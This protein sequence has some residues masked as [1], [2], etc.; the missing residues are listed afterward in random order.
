MKKSFALAAV[1]ASLAATPAAAA[2]GVGG[3]VYGARIE[4]GVTEVELR[5]GRLSGDAADGAQRQ[6]Q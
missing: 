1:A 2:P 4:K 6:A 5:Y 3:K